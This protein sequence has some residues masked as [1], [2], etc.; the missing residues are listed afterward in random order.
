MNSFQ[1]ITDGKEL[2][3]R[4]RLAGFV[5]KLFRY[6]NYDF[7]HDVYKQIIYGET[8]CRTPVEEKLKNSHDA[9]FFLLSHHQNPLSQELLGKFFYLLLG[10]EVDRAM[11]TRLATLAFTVSDQPGLESAVFFHLQAYAETVELETDVRLLVSLMFFNYFLTKAAI[12]TVQILKSELP[13]YEKYRDSYLAGKETEIYGFLLDLVRN[14]KFQDRGYYENLR[15]LTV[16]MII[17]QFKKDRKM[18]I[19]NY[20]I[21]KV[22][23]FGSFAKGHPRIDSDIDLLVTFSQDLTGEEKSA[24]ITFLS[25]YYFNIF[26]RYIDCLEVGEYLCDEFIKEYSKIK[27]IY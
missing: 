4:K 13:I 10:R 26:H 6:L 27:T 2:I 21:K 7:G 14:A 15:P 9:Y 22:S 1:D 3:V 8:A 16:G 5:E 17:R 18:L 19:E 20:G 25:R 23:L 24:N 12:P 11:L